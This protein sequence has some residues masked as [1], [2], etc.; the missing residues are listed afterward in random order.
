[1]VLLATEC[2]CAHLHIHTNRKRIKNPEK[3]PCKMKF[4]GEAQPH[5]D[6]VLWGDGAA[7]PLKKS[8]SCVLELR[9]DSRSLSTPRIQLFN[10]TMT[11]L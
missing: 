4:Q 5:Q 1:M 6:L 10:S 2:R 9:W 8:Y 3:T 7:T 11:H